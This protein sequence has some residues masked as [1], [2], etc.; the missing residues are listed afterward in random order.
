ME[1]SPLHYDQAGFPSGPGELIMDSVKTV[2]FSVRVNENLSN[3][4]SPTRGIR[5]GD[6]ISPYL[7]LICAEGLSSTLKFSG[8]QFGKRSLGRNPCTLGF[9]LIVC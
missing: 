5:Q 2:S 9:P 3:I 1:L 4:F 8:P 6:P 7:F